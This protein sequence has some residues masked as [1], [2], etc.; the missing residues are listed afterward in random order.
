MRP[1]GAIRWRAWPCPIEDRREL[2]SPR[3]GMIPGFSL[4]SY[5]KLVDHTSRL[6]R[7]GKA[8]ISA[9]L[10]GVFERLGCSA[11]S[12]QIQIKE[13]CGDRLVGRFFAASRAKLREVGERLGVR[14]L[15]NLRGC[16]IR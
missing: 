5:V 11:Q 12:W 3:E 4:G 6:F 10:A 16:P 8:S 2:D 14:R 15:V 9:E 7:E 13:L 1:A